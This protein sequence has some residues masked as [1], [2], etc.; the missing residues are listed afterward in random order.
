MKER[1]SNSI[2]TTVRHAELISQKHENIMW[3][4]GI[5]GEATPTQMRET[6]LFLI[7][8]HVGLR[9]GDEHYNL[10]RDTFT[11]PSQFSFKRNEDG[12]RCLVNTEDCTTKTNDGGVKSMKK[13]CKVAWVY[14]SQ[15][16][17]HCPVRLI[18]KYISL[19]PPVRMN[20]K[21]NFYLRSLDRVTP[22]QWYGEQVVGL[23]S[24]KTGN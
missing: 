11:N 19:L 6:V 22:A 8:I 21:P 13:E 23:N 12:V 18:D 20:R 1:A 4:K 24:L 2:G 10:R 14:P 7:G 3:E 17:V 16:K 5:L 15:N 9:A